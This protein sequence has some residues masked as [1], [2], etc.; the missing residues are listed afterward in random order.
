[1]AEDSIRFSLE[2]ATTTALSGIPVVVYARYENPT[3][4]HHFVGNI[5]PILPRPN[6]VWT[7]PNGEL[8][9]IPSY[10]GYL[11]AGEPMPGLR[12]DIKLG[13]KQ[14][15][16]FRLTAP[17][18]H[19]FGIG[20]RWRLTLGVQGSKFPDPRM[21]ARMASA[22]FICRDRD[23]DCLSAKVHPFASQIALVSDV[24]SDRDVF[25]RG[26]DPLAAIKLCADEGDWQAKSILFVRELRLNNRDRVV[27]AYRDLLD[28]PIEVRTLCDCRLLNALESD[29][30]KGFSLSKPEVVVRE[31]NRTALRELIAGGSAIQGQ[32]ERE[33]TTGA[34]IAA[35]EARWIRLLRRTFSI[36]DLVVPNTVVVVVPPEKAFRGTRHGPSEGAEERSRGQ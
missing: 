7:A 12:S 32:L 9:R 10:G 28:A 19:R 8:H 26:D 6:W 21:P 34:G 14:Q 11:T 24:G 17:T 22:E 3:K 1:M 29:V 16:V 2:P 31:S 27:T 20:T 15:L 23:I 4:L 36:N 5:P 25:F 33:L 35:E 30:R 18:P 13:P